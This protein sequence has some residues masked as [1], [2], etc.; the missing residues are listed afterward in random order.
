M[1]F[2]KVEFDF[3]D[4]DNEKSLEIK[5]SSAETID[6]SGRKKVEETTDDFDIE[7]IDDTPPEDRDVNRQN[8][9]KMSL[10]KS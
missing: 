5:G 4:P 1:P 7:I 10:K 2:E 3:P 9:P 6:T 8:L